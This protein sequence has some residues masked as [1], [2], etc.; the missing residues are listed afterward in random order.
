VI[1]LLRFMDHQCA[2]LSESLELAHP[3]LGA[4]WVY[5]QEHSH[6]HETGIQMSK[7]AIRLR[8]DN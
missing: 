7:Y 8:I 6:C 5:E 3:D 2:E 4:L 1:V